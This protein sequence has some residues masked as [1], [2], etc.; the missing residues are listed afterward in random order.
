MKLHLKTALATGALALAAVPAT[1]AA[2]DYHPTPEP[3]KTKPAPPQHAPAYGKRCQGKSKQH[4]KGEKGTEFSRCVRALKKAANNPRMAP[5]QV[6]KNE[7]KEHVKG[8]KGT[9][10]SRCV[11]LVAQ[12]RREER[13]KAREEANL[14]DATASGRPAD[15]PKGKGPHY[16]PAPEGGEA[17]PAHAKAHGKRCQGKSKQHVKGEKGTEFS[18]CVKALAK[19]EDNPKMHPRRACKGLSKKHVKGEKGTEFSRC[20]KEVA[21]MR[22]EEREETAV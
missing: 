16:S 20:V 7:S 4:V 2:N 19:A 11:K 9:A 1:A 6:C 8:E 14:S 18:R 15:A 5:G 17:P 10:F 3:P 22:R 21:Q 12:Q 13:R